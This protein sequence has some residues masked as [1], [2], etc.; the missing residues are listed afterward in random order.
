MMAAQ[1]K[2]MSPPRIHSGLAAALEEFLRDMAA[3]WPP[4]AFEQR[5]GEL[6]S[7]ALKDIQE[8]LAKLDV[9]GMFAVRVM[10]LEFIELAKL[11]RLKAVN[12][13]TGPDLA[14]SETAT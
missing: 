5:M 13:D 6:R 7:D 10:Q 14:S 3:D 11:R 4:G 8:D 12:D 1:S 2:F 9:V